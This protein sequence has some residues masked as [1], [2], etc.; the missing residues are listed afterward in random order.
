[1]PI[2]IRLVYVEAVVEVADVDDDEVEDDDDVEELHNE[3][4]TLK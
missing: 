4:T 2:Y 1:M 3:Q